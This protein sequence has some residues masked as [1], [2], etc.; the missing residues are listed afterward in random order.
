MMMR[1]HASAPGKLVVAGDYAVLEGAPA[2]VL[3]LDRRAQVD[4]TPCAD[5]T[6]CVDAADLGVR[7][8]HG[9]FD[10][11]QL[12]WDTDRATAGKLALVTCVLRALAQSAAPDPVH[13][14]LDTRAFFDAGG[15]AKLGLG[16]SA[17]LTVA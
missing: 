13:V 4:V 9:R 5:A 2:V 3:A 1:S 17:A 12:H 7:G 15:S 14:T 8:I 10:G 16:S 6:F 11:G